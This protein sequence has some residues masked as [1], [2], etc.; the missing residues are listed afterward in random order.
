LSGS[1]FPKRP[2]PDPNIYELM[3]KFVGRKIFVLKNV[4]TIFAFNKKS[5]DM[6]FT[7][8]M[9]LIKIVFLEFIYCICADPDP[10]H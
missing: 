1:D 3:D 5:T 4:P 10:Q 8:Y 7:T 9:A 6:D 2:D